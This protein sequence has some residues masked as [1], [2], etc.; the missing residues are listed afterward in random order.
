M[1]KLR[2]QL[3]IVVLALA[4][5]GVL[6]LSQQHNPLQQIVPV[7]PAS[8]GTYSEALIGSYSRLNPILD[9]YNPADRDVDR[10]LFR[11]LIRFDDHGIPEADLAEK[12]NV[13]D[14]GTS[15]SFSIR[16]DAAWHDGKPVTADD[17][18]FTIGLLQ[19]EKIPVPEDLR[20]LWKQVKVTPL[21]EKTVQFTL[22]EPYAPFLDYLTFGLLPKHLLGN[23]SPEQIVNASFNLQPIGNGP[24]R[25][26]HLINEDGKI[27]GVV[28][29]V[30]KEFYDKAPFIDQVVF[31]YFP[32]TKSALDAYHKGDVLGISEITP[33]LLSQVLKE[34]DLKVYTE[35][36]PRL[37]L[38]YLNLNNSKL[39]FLKDAAIRR[40]LM[41][42]LNRQWMVDHALQGQAILADSPILPGSW[43]YYDGVEHLSYDSN[44]AI[45][46][47]K[48]AGY[49]IP[50]EGGDVRTSKDGTALSFQLAYPD[51]A[52]YQALAEAIQRDWSKIGVQVELKPV[53]YDALVDD[54]LNKRSY[55][56]VLVDLNMARS[57]DPDPYPFWDGAQIEEGQNYAQWDDRQ[58]SE[59]LETA[60]ITSDIGD[61]TKAYKNFQ[62]R[63][64]MEMPALPLFYPVYSYAV[65]AQVQN[66]R[67]GPFFDP[68]DRF[69]TITSWYLVAKRP[70]EQ[71]TLTPNPNP[72]TSSNP[73]N[74]P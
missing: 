25:F 16:K 48:A 33:D 14:D 52:E 53:A 15:Y 69:N 56:A 51:S 5:I 26:D 7:Q 46:A 9:F 1:K 70:T 30:N 66:V 42:G 10:L 28:L 21:N 64:A 40:A 61:R 74:Q 44:A 62:V 73:T 17:V 68:S 55:D 45:T 54:Y 32:D 58:A 35:R 72:T 3:L 8:G 31:R 23:T 34:K 41:T 2:W 24:Y 27:A 18:S 49:T 57:P 20:D 13:S 43:A 47:L 38:I 71:T 67:I 37:T 29:T 12:W 60:R 4:A 6:L 65:D 11:G 63:F 36:M 59:F 19:N 50:A 22:P 39:A